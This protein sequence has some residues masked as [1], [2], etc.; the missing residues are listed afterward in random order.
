MHYIYQKNKTTNEITKIM[1]LEYNPK[2]IAQRMRSL[3][4]KA[5]IPAEDAEFKADVTY[6]GVGY[7]IGCKEMVTKHLGKKTDPI[8]SVETKQID[9]VWHAIYDH[10]MPANTSGHKIGKPK[11]S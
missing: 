8:V 2:R 11:K 9:G 3:G 6:G 10:V 4:Y 5:A 7:E 1:Q